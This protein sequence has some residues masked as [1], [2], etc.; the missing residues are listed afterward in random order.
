MV[1]LDLMVNLDGL[2]VV[3]EEVIITPKVQVADTVDLGMVVQ[4]YQVDHLLVAVMVLIVML[5]AQLVKEILVVMQLEVV[6]ERQVVLVPILVVMVDL[7]LLFLDTKL[8]HHK[9]GLQEQQVVI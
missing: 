2:P 4:Y 6:V 1:L 3:V 8:H 9:Q 7:V 5:A